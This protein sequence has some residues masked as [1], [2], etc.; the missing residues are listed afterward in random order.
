M[1]EKTLPRQ[2]VSRRRKAPTCQGITITGED[3]PLVAPVFNTLCITPRVKLRN[4][5]HGWIPSPSPCRLCE[6]VECMSQSLSNLTPFRNKLLQSNHL[7]VA[8]NKLRILC[9]LQSPR[10][11][12]LL[13]GPQ[14]K[15]NFDPTDSRSKTVTFIIRGYCTV[16]LD[17]WREATQLTLLLP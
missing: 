3:F 14:I 9:L 7:L 10:F 1:P 6:H 16:I 12:S 4:E 2:I 8:Q 17:G 13:G 15:A 11:L 5:K